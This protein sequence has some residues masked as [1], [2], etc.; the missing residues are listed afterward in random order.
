M[1]GRT[2]PFALIAFLLCWMQAASSQESL[3]TSGGEAIGTGGS[4]SYSVGQVAYTYIPGTTG[5]INEGVQQSYVEIMV[6]TETPQFDISIRLFPNPTVAYTS[7]EINDFDSA[8]DLS[9]FSCHVFSIYGHLLMSETMASPVT[10][11]NTSMLTSGMYL[12]KVNFQNQ[13]IK[14]FRF[15]KTE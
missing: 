9:D 5:N 2:T 3:N 10:R 14:T 12:V 13:P 11:L 7:V 1:N 15:I 8:Y 6:N 4:V